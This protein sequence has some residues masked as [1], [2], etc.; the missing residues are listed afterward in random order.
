MR[1]HGEYREINGEKEFFTEVK[2]EERVVC[3]FFRE[4]W[5][6]KVCCALGVRTRCLQAAAADV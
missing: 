3:H 6:C 2:G 4:N 5:P 1:G